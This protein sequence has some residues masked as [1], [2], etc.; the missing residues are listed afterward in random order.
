ME[1]SESGSLQ[2]TDDNLKSVQDVYWALTI[3]EENPGDFKR[4]ANER[5]ATPYPEF[6]SPMR[7]IRELKELT[8]EELSLL[9]GIP[10]DILE[11]AES[12]KLE[13]TGEDLEAVRKVYWSLSALEATA[14][15]YRRLLR[16]FAA[17]SGGGDESIRCKR[18]SD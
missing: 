17:D 8:I 7:V 2:M 11:K 5:L 18:K 3:G 10:A 13:I 14:A 6:G 12:D 1:T 9:S 4:L 15:D 16:K